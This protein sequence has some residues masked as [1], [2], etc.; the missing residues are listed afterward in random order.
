MLVLLWSYCCLFAF[1]FIVIA[2]EHKRLLTVTTNSKASP[3]IVF[4]MCLVVYPVLGWLA[5]VRYGRYAMSKWSLRVLWVVSVLFCLADVVVD[6]LHSSSLL[7]SHSVRV[8]KRV[9]RFV[10]YGPITLGLGGFLANVYQ[11]AIDQLVDAS[12]DEISSFF[13]WLVWVWFLSGISCGISQL[14]VGPAYELTGYLL[15]PLLTTMGVCLDCVF[16]HWLVKEPATENPFVLIF[17]VLCYAVKNKHP[18]LR[19][20]F[21]YW[22][23]KRYHRID[24]AKTKY[25]GPFTTEQVEDVKTFFRIVSVLMAGAFFVSLYI[26]VYPV[27]YKVMDHLHD[28]YQY[29]ECYS[30]MCLS[31][32]FQRVAVKYSGD[33]IMVVFLP[34]F[35]FVFHPLFKRYSHISILKRVCLSL[36]TLLL[37]LAACAGIEFAAQRER[38]QLTN[39][40]S[41]AL[42]EGGVPDSLPLDYKWMMLPYVLLSVAHFLI[43]TSVG[44]FL[45]AQSPYSMKGLLFGLVYGFMGVFG[46]FGYFLTWSLQVLAEK[47]LS[48]R[49]GCL[50]WYLILSLGLLLAVFVV[51]FL[52]FKCYR[53]RLRGDD[54]HN[55]QMFAVDYYSRYIDN[56]YIDNRK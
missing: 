40:T 23:D 50:F 10:M 39:D 25:G 3:V 36:I 48:Y 6:S 47:K 46:V 21:T 7:S 42:T 28:Q 45:C 8:S 27:F 51:F 4:T 43:L 24:L 16:N 37:S 34:L 41:C 56:R 52:V 18:R 26:A 31:N 53:R 30:V 54:E 5:D 2:D 19:S 20:A 1:Q 55:E 12:S 11:L 33:F 29:Q 44:E 17:Q 9:V 38:H 32:C 13:R 14:C 15:L 22:D 35:E 49:Y